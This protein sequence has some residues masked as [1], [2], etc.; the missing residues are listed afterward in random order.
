MTFQEICQLI[1]SITN[2]DIF[3]EVV[4]EGLQPYVVVATD[5]LTEVMQLLFGYESFYFDYLSCL[6]GIDN[7]PEKGTMEVVYNLY[8]IPYDRHFTV[9]V[10]VARNKESES[11][12]VVPTV[13]D[14]WKSADWHER[15]TYDLLGIGFEGHPDLRR[16]LM[17]SDWE[18]YPLRKDYKEMEK[19]HGIKVAY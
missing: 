1:T 13:S 2:K 5:N 11:L 19:Y 8:S 10:I 14:I 17:P 16:L 6:T 7:G 3:E 4:D 15:E 12:P 18:G 9:K